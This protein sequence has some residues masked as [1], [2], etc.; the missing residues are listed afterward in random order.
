MTMDKAFTAG[1]ACQKTFM[2]SLSDGQNGTS[3]GP[4]T[5]AAPKYN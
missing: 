5:G 1:C 2:D 4:Q 3:F